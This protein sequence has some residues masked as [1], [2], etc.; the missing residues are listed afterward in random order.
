MS[1]GGAIQTSSSNQAKCS[2]NKSCLYEGIAETP[3][4]EHENQINRGG[5]YIYKAKW[6]KG[7]NRTHETTHTFAHEN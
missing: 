3:R 1:E 2:A 4:F 6:D 7:L 5:V